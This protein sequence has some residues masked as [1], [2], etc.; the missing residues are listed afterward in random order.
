MRMHAIL[1]VC[2]L[3]RDGGGVGGSAALSI[4]LYLCAH[5]LSVP[6]PSHSVLIQFQLRLCINPSTAVLHELGFRRVAG[7]HVDCG[8]TARSTPLEL[9][10]RVSCYCYYTGGCGVLFPPRVPCLPCLVCM[11]SLPAFPPFYL[12]SC[13]PAFLPE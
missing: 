12:P 3:Q 8:G 5:F 11:P 13:L 9:Q 2:G 7:Y 6:I 10:Q 4:F 1:R